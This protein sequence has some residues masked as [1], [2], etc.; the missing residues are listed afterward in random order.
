MALITKER[1][2]DLSTG[3]TVTVHLEIEGIYDSHFGA[4][5]DGNRGVGRWL[6]EGH[7]YEIETEDDLS[8]DETSELDGLVEEIVY[9]GTWDF[10]NADPDDDADFESDEYF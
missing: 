4:D 9:D 7:S 6:V 2:V 3:K 1:E 5:A 10:E 8:D